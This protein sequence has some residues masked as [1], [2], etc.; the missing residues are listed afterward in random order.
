MERNAPYI[1]DLYPTKAQFRSGEPAILTVELCNPG[2]YEAT[3]AVRLTITAA[4]EPVAVLIREAVVPAG[5]TLVFDMEAGRF[6]ADLAGF[7]ADAELLANGE[8]LDALSGAFDVASDWRRS[9]RYGFLSDF[10]AAELG[11]GEDVRSM[12]KLHL[13]LVQFYD[14]MYRHDELVAAEDDYTDLMGRQVSLPVVREKIALCRERGMKAIAY[15]AVYAASREFA[16]RHPDWALYTSAGEPFDFIGIF[17][18]MNIAPDS[19]W[20]GHIVLQ[21]R[22]AVE[23]VGFDGIHMD[24]YGFPKTALS[25]LGGK[26]RI[27]RL[28]DHFPALID[29]TRQSLEEAADDVCLIFNNVGNWPVDTVALAAQDAIYVEVWKPYERYHHIRDIVR[30][31]DHLGRGK[32]VILAAYLKPFREAGEGGAEGAQNAALLLTAVITAHGAYHLLLGEN[33]G[34]LTQGYYVDHSSIGGAFMRK[35]RDYYDYLVRYVHI[36]YDKRLRDVSMTHADGDNEEYVFEGFACSMYGEPGKV[37]AIVREHERRKVLHFVNLTGA[38]DDYWNEAKPAAPPVEG[39]I[40][41]IAV[42]RK[43]K[44]AFR[45]SPDAGMGK[46]VALEPVYEIGKRGMTARFALPA[47]RVWDSLVLEFAGEG[48]GEGEGE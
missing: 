34:V 17:R 32:N 31:A 23:R 35:L 12:C 21:Y 8:P 5:A 13:N 18:I 25:R 47:L 16:E 38:A 2:G 14:W 20:S 15:G 28:A 19:P 1:R 36:W 37:W 43:A 3:L 42:E 24:T 6:E 9:T 45:A 41:R 33:G 11:D 46:P 39:R 27:E 10:A 26:E 4:T 44:A 48:E 29:R 7:G 30:W 22:Q 40:V